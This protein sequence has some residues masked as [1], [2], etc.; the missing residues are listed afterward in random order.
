MRVYSKICRCLPPP[1]RMVSGLRVRTSRMPKSVQVGIL[2]VISC[3]GGILSSALRGQPAGSN[4]GGHGREYWR[5]IVKNHYAVPS[6]QEAFPLAL[7][8]NG[9]LGSTDPEL[10][11]DLAYSILYTWIAEQRQLSS[12][13]LI[14]LLGKWQANL[15]VGIGE[16]GTDSVFLRSFSV[17]GLATLAERDL[18]DPFLG[19][20]RFQGLLQ[21]GLTYLGAERDLRAFDEKKGWMHAT[22]HSADLLAALARNRFF[23]EKDQA[24]VLVAIAQRLA[25][26][27]EIYTHGEQDRLAD[28]ATAIVARHDF[29][30]TSWRIWVDAIDKGDQIVFQQSPPKP[31]AVRRF[32]NDTYFL[33]AIVAEISLRPPTAK[34]QS[35]A[36]EKAVLAVLRPRSAM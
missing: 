36:A 6:G 23:T 22:A 9:Y 29:D 1:L 11:D 20:E 18:K 5:S 24:Q 16:I 3:A 27:E 13:Q 4:S 35:A 17:I 10:R 26:A 14:T 15:R 30:I 33:Q 32:Y 7:E 8:L 12:E 19:R 34:A 31:E 2:L 21:N 28:V 25:T